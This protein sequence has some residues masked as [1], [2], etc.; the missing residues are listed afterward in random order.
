MSTTLHTINT[1]PS[2]QDTFTQ[3][4][5]ALSDGDAVLL[6]ENAAY[7]AMP[8]HRSTFPH[9]LSVYALAV[10]LEARGVTADPSV[11]VITD[12]ECVNLTLRHARVIS[13]F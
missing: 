10:D 4:M 1:A 12:A 2:D 3:C 8:I 6:I 13:W 11:R 5:S 7:W 9:P